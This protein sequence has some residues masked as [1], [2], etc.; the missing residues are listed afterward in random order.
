MIATA[1]WPRR[2]SSRLKLD[3]SILTPEADRS[4][5]AQ[6][7]VGRRRGGAAGPALHFPARR[8][9]S[10]PTF[11]RSTA[12]PL[13]L[14]DRDRPGPWR[15]PPARRHRAR[16]LR[17]LGGGSPRP[18]SD[19]S[20]VQLRLPLRPRAIRTKATYFPPKKWRWPRMRSDSDWPPE[21]AGTA[22]G[23][24]TQ[25][26]DYLRTTRAVRPEA[27]SPHFRPSATAVPEL[28]VSVEP[29]SGSP[30]GGHLARRRT[31]CRDSPRLRP[32]ISPQPWHPKSCSSAEH[33][34][35][36]WHTPAHLFA[37]RFRGL[38]L[39]VSS[40]DP[41]GRGNSWP[42]R[43][44]VIG[45]PRFNSPPQRLQQLHGKPPVSLS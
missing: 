31:K 6:E 11:S 13:A 43:V 22:S 3:T 28:A 7:R 14:I 9:L 20:R 2:D 42:S 17:R 44:T 24:L 5:A 8:C 35:S 36:L 41:T 25:I 4:A 21:I 33:R 10:V 34:A 40:A 12:E 18:D 32:K 27:R 45:Q 39:D 1:V 37:M 38:R 23:A 30:T 19:A 15:I 29:R 26:A 16:R